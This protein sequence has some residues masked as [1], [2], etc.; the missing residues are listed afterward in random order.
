MSKPGILFVVNEIRPGGAEMFV[1]RLA[2]FLQAEYNI[3]VF[4]CFTEN[5]D[6]SFVAQFQATVPF[7]FLPH[8]K[9]N[10]P[11]WREFLYWKMNAIAAMF[12]K[13]GLYVRLRKADR[14]RHFRHELKK[15]NIRIV[16][17]S[18]SHSDGF[19]VNFIKKH[20]SIPAVISVHSA[21]NSENW[22][23]LKDKHEFSQGVKSMLTGADALL[24]TAN[25]N[26]EILKH[27]PLPSNILVEK[28]Y[29]GYEPQLVTQTRLELN[30][31]KDAFVIT[32]MARGIPEKGWEE[33]LN[34]F[35]IL[36]NRHPNSLL[37]LIHTDTDYI[38]NLKH[39]FSHEP[40]IHF[41]GFMS[42]P[43]G[44]L[45]NSNCTILPSHYPESLPYAITESLA[46]GIPVFATAIA[47]IPNMLENADG[48]AGAIIPFKDGKADANVLANQLFHAATDLDYSRNLQK[49]AHQSFKKFSMAQ[50]GNR[51][52][53][54]FQQLIN[55]R[56]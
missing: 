18:A 53:E 9:K 19:A 13:S 21:Y 3:Y 55:A 44:I 29:L 17:S 11:E 37:V 51:Y 24:F 52:R 34:A 5:D 54:I 31:P 32:M 6:P 47:E 43:S 20:F 30:W 42:D 28:V 8:P 33:A 39:R 2:K 1:I 15:R 56:L 10:I 38:T 35:T 12:G 50:C 14:I 48:M 49:L 16:N 41:Q 26:L 36:V 46:Y 40:R 23:D 27:I 22:G 7:Q 4:S 45:K 25:H